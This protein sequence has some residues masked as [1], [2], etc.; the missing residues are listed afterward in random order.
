MIY[1]FASE[2]QFLKDSKKLRKSGQKNLYDKFK[3][4]FSLI[5]KQDLKTQKLLVK[6][7]KDH[8]LEGK[9]KGYRELH[10]KDDFLVVYK[11][12]HIKKCI[13]FVRADTHANIFD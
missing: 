13:F 7:Y 12:D 4:V 6:Q 3:F 10:V 9:W 5:L 8:P 2:R 1:K 11:V